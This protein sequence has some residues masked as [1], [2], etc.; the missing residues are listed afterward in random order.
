MLVS[1]SNTTNA[2]PIEDRRQHHGPGKHCHLLHYPA[3]L[4][5]YDIAL[6]NAGSIYFSGRTYLRAIPHA[7]KTA[8]GMQVPMLKEQVARVYYGDVWQRNRFHWMPL[9]SAHLSMLPG[10]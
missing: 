2:A 5:L 6:D 4:R 3:V 1:T 9:C 10:D 7:C 8:L